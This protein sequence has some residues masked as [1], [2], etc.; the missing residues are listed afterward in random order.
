MKVHHLKII[1]PYFKDVWEGRKGF[2]VR[3]NDRDYKVGDEVYL[4]QYNPDTDS[5]TGNEVLVIISYVLKDYHAIKEGYVVFGFDPIEH[6]P[7]QLN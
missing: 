4:K 3:I 7:G 6:I 5:Y 1:N 2:E